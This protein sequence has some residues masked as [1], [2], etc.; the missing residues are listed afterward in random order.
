MLENESGNVRGPNGLRS[1]WSAMKRGL[2]VTFPECGPAPESG[3]A[4]SVGDV[5]ADV[6]G[7]YPHADAEVGAQQG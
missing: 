3:V 5:V 6:F 4:V 2:T 7:N 1:P